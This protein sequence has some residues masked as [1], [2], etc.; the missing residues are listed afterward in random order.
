MGTWSCPEVHLAHF[1]SCGCCVV[2]IRRLAQ[3]VPPYSRAELVA[4]HVTSGRGC[5]IGLRFDGLDIVVDVL[6]CLWC[7]SLASMV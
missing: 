3:K 7:Y 4:D 6:W 2:T 1:G 5:S